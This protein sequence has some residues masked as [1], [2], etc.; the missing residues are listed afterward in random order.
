MA[1]HH[2][3]IVR[4]PDQPTINDAEKNLPSA[5]KSAGLSASWDS[6]RNSRKLNEASVESLVGGGGVLSWDAEP[7]SLPG[8]SKVVNDE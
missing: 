3:D 1:A 7:P 8:K 2:R 6:M 4:R 5:H